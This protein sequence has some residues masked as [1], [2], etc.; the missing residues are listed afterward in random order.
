MATILLTLLS[1]TMLVMLYGIFRFVILARE[2]SQRRR[3]FDNR[4]NGRNTERRNE[5]RR[6][7]FR[8]GALPSH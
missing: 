4:V 7:G 3:A 5:D 1:L 8:N 6:M 2:Y